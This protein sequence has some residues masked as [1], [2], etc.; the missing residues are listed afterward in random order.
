MDGVIGMKDG[1][2]K[3]KWD[4][5]FP[6]A[7]LRSFGAIGRGHDGF[8]FTRSG[9]PRAFPALAMTLLFLSLSACTMSKPPA[10]DLP[11]ADGVYPGEEITVGR[12]ENLYVVAQ[13][14]GVRLREIIV[15]NKMTPPYVIKAGQKLYL[16][17]KDGYTAPTPKAAPLAPVDK[18]SLGGG[19]V[20]APLSGDDSV[21][22]VPLEPP[23]APVVIEA[24]TAP[25]KT[26]G[27]AQQQA[28][29]LAAPQRV[30]SNLSSSVKPKA[31]TEVGEVEIPA[32]NFEKKEEPKLAASETQAEFPSFAWP[33]RG[34]VISA[35]GPKGKGLDND[36][37]NIAAPKGSPV[38]AADSGMVAYA[39]SEMK[40]FGNLVLIR[41]QGG[42][43]TAYA[44][45]ERLVVAKDSV[46]A[47]GDMI[48]T[49]GATGGVT[50]PQL[51][52]EARREGKPVDP[53]LV[54]K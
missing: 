26:E 41:H 49:V 19:V 7:L 17:T 40:G 44:H 1:V 14:H 5:R 12:G 6:P 11:S 35:F 2:K 39:G 43:V 8:C 3:N 48:G 10:Y 51:H 28:G 45:L 31:A 32:L 20:S 16:P 52:F 21:R 37:I 54:L 29:D 34:T 9:L 46:V 18:G 38:K 33:V 15:V 36:G 30:V 27:T 23:S 24:P 25:P 22:A 4:A 53:E 50:S 13:K 47:K 42:W